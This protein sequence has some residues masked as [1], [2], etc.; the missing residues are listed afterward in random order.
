MTEPEHRSKRYGAQVSERS[1]C[2]ALKSASKLWGQIPTVSPN[3]AAYPM[4][5]DQEYVRARP[6]VLAGLAAGRYL[7]LSR[8]CAPTERRAE[9]QAVDHEVV[10]AD[11]RRAEQHR[12][13]RAALGH[14]VPRLCDGG[15]PLSDVEAA[16]DRHRLE[17]ESGRQQSVSGCVIPSHLRDVSARFGATGAHDEAWQWANP[18]ARRLRLNVNMRLN[19][20][21]G[22][23]LLIAASLGPKAAF[24]YT[25]PSRAVDDPVSGAV[26]VPLNMRFWRLADLDP[27]EPVVLED[28]AGN[29]VPLTPSEIAV[30]PR[31]WESSPLR[32][33]TPTAALRANTQYCRP[34]GSPWFTTGTT[35]LDTPPAAPVL[36]QPVVETWEY[37]ADYYGPAYRATFTGLSRPPTSLLLVNLDG[38]ATFDA[39]TLSGAVQGVQ[40]NF[41][42][43]DEFALEDLARC[44]NNWPGVALGATTTVAL[45]YLDIAGNFSGWSDA[46]TIVVPNTWTYPAAD[47]GSEGG[48]E[49]SSGAAG[50]ASV[51]AAG[52]SG[53]APAS[54]V[55]GGGCSWTGRVAD[56]LQAW[57]SLLFVG[58]LFCFQRLP[59]NPRKSSG[60]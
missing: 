1:G 33:Y 52:N 13:A 54:S 48:G 42:R 4:R 43:P 59:R 25:C 53:Q 55:S 40:E 44:G 16:L 57:L 51:N 15:T 17:L 39:S 2:P 9:T 28:C 6:V 47:G 37:V 24:A 3:I 49:A 10:A 29:V 45:G 26:D 30:P 56:P 38:A 11:A 34:G 35:T 12:S 22:I 31:R 60:I 5:S 7:R 18:Q 14:V 50:G 41:G 32:V 46:V 21:F 19:R 20:L 58:G 36:G 8:Y 23:G 27:A